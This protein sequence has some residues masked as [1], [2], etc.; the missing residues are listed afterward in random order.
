MNFKIKTEWNN[1]PINH[2]KPVEITLTWD[3]G[4]DFLTAAFDA[5]FF[6]DPE[7]PDGPAG[8]PFPQLWEYEGWYL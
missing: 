8:Q 2:T 4:E 6:D 1:R 3:A 5:P 7:A